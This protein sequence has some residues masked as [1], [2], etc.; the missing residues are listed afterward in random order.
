MMIPK[1]AP[2]QIVEYIPC[3]NP[4]KEKYFVYEWYNITK[5]MYYVGYHKTEDGTP[6]DGYYHSSKDK[7]FADD[8]STCEWRYTI[9]DWGNQTLMLGLE[10]NWKLLAVVA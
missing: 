2:K 9:K 3:D 5:D 1:F 8:F 6:F 4:E 7:E 10:M